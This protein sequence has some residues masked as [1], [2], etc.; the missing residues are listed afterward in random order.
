MYFYVNLAPKESTAPNNGSHMSSQMHFI[1]TYDFYT[2][3]K[4]SCVEA[5]LCLQFAQRQ[6]FY[7]VMAKPH[8]PATFPKETSFC[9]CLFASAGH[10]IRPKRVL[11]L[12]EFA[13]R[14]ANSFLS[15][16]APADK[17]NETGISNQ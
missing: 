5:D 2:H 17:G 14:Q 3:N 1:F 13:P 7:G 10:K 9:H 8:L 15:E 16:L 12:K 11:T 6:V 4:W